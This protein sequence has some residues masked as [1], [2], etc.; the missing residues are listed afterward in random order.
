V[1]IK[2]GVVRVGLVSKTSL[3]VPTGSEILE[4]YCAEVALERNV[5][6]SVEFDGEAALCEG[7]D[8]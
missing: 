6:L 2:V 4:K 5:M 3:P 8:F 1:P 7:W